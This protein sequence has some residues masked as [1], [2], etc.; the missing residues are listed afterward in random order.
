[1][2]RD[3]IF[4]TLFA[5]LFFA[6]II[7]FTEQG[8][9]KDVGSRAIDTVNV[10][11]AANDGTGDPLRTAFIK[12]NAALYMLDSLGVDELDATD[13]SYIKE[14]TS[15]IQTQLNAKVTNPMTTAGDLIIGGTSG[16]PARL[17]AGITGVEEYSAENY[18]A[19]GTGNIVLSIGAA[20]TDP[21]LTV[22][23][24]A[25]SDTT[26]TAVVG[27]IVFKTSDG[28]FYGCVATS[29]KK[30]KQLDN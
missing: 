14:T 1:M 16:T 6:V 10:G 8:K 13:V 4:Y 18:G 17:A 22:P 12:L 19:T 5:V 3:L 9:Q 7:L 2:K 29:G 30:W 21:V 20:L 15:A 26:V 24:V 11:S 23:Q 28:H 25:A 27:K